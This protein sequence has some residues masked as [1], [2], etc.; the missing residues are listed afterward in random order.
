MKCEE[1]KLM[2]AFVDYKVNSIQTVD[3][4]RKW[5]FFNVKVEI[6]AMSLTNWYKVHDC[7]FT[8]WTS[9]SRPKTETLNSIS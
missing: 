1:L 4:I 8:I 3:L 7:T 9:N 5:C 2:P 6:A